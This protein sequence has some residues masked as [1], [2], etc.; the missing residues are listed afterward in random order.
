MLAGDFLRA[1]HGLGQQLP[2]TQLRQNRICLV[3]GHLK[4]HAGTLPACLR[5]KREHKTGRVF[6]AAV[7]PRGVLR[8]ENGPAEGRINT[9]SLVQIDGGPID[10]R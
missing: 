7:C 10:P 2:F 3:L 9:H 1:A 8:L 4:G 5:I 6:C